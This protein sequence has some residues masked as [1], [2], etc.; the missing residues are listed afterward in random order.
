MSPPLQIPPLVFQYW[1]SSIDRMWYW[2]LKASTNEKV[3]QGEAYVTKAGC[4]RAIE[5]AKHAAQA[6]LENLSEPGASD[7][8]TARG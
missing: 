1:Q 5:M 4:L 2:H 6:P 3:A 7:E 8:K